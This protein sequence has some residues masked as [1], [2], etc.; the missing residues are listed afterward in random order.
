MSK[1]ASKNCW[2]LRKMDYVELGDESSHAI[3]PEAPIFVNVRDHFAA[4]GKTLVRQFAKPANGPRRRVNVTLPPNPS[5]DQLNNCRGNGKSTLTHFPSTDPDQSQPDPGGL[6][7]YGFEFGEISRIAFR[8]EYK[9]ACEQANVLQPKH[10]DG[11]AFFNTTVTYRT[12]STVFM[13]YDSL[14]E[15]QLAPDRRKMDEG[16]TNSSLG[17]MKHL[18]DTGNGADVHFLVGGGDEKELMPAHKTILMAASDVFGAM[19]PFDARNAETKPV[20]VPDVE[21]GAFKAML[22]F[23]YVD[24]VS[25]LNGD[26]AIA[27]LYAAKKYDLPELVVSCLNFPIWKLSNVF[28]AF[29]QTRFLGE[30]HIDVNA[31][32]LILSEEF[33]EIDQKSLCEILDRDELMISEE[34]AIWNAAL[35]WADE[36]CRQNGKEP[37]A[38][39]RR[40]ML[41][42]A[43]FKIRFPLILHEDFSDNIVSSGV[44]TEGELISVFLHYS[45]PDR[46]RPEPYQLQFP[47]NG[48]AFTGLTIQNRWDSAACHDLALI[49]PNRLSVQITA[50]NPMYRS[51]LAIRPIPKRKFGI[52]YYE[53][54]LVAQKGFVSIG[55]AAKRMPLDKWVGWYKGT[56]A[57]SRW[58]DFWGHAV[59][60]CS[61]GRNGRPFIA[62]KP[63]FGEG[64]VI[65]CGVNL[66]T[67]QI[68]YTQNGQRLGT[69]GLCVDS[70]ADLFPCVSLYCSGDKIEANFGPN[71][72]FNIAAD[73]I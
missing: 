64:D 3:P 53:V 4:W 65:G 73:G 13:P 72:K 54:T 38:A 57:Y 14:V 25:G 52:F 26:N 20:E 45:R 63:K 35:R 22:S 67:R 39:N 11:N 40:A 34:I 47:T 43:L 41:G 23:I 32:A 69:A 49:G 5:N 62:G 50:D 61:H 31:D 55:L 30:G 8:P 9:I 33:L 51:V 71:F 2:K 66:A 15:L 6:S 68:I 21:V 12:D 18:L 42:P 56:Y 58:G 37:T 70:A 7:T 10:Y 48:R 36:K 24:D 46:A 1:K 16:G 27:V 17:R 59:E 28:F 60:E 19:F 44:L 29:G